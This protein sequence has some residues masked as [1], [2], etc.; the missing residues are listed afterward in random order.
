[1]LPDTWPDGTGHTARDVLSPPAASRQGVW[2]HPHLTESIAGGRA[3][4]QGT[5]Y[6]PQ[7]PTRP[8]AGSP[9]LYPP[10]PLTEPLPGG[11]SFLLLLEAT[12]GSSVCSRV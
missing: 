6:L 12:T 9:S 1:M 11:N 5:Q 3:H 10:P 4:C 2:G 8:L 7:L